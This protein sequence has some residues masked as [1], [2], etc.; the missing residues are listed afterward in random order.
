M[1]A[2]ARLCYFTY[3]GNQVSEFA[4]WDPNLDNSEVTKELVLVSVFFSPDITVFYLMPFTFRHL[5]YAL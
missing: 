5:S 2:P 3:S 1:S 4:R